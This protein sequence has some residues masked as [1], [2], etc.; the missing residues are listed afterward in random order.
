M[1]LVF[2]AL[3]D[4]ANVYYDYDKKLGY[5]MDGTDTGGTGSLDGN[6]WNVL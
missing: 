5:C 1:K 4:A 3:R 2:G 6:G